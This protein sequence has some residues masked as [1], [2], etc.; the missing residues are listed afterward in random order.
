MVLIIARIYQ[1]VMKYDKINSEYYGTIGVETHLKD[2]ERNRLYVGDIVEI[3]CNGTGRKYLKPVIEHNGRMFVM[4]LYGVNQESLI[5]EWSIKRI[6][7]YKELSLGF[8]GV[9]DL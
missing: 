2:V 3:S 9:D 8:T 4:G 5:S 1:D 7:S 6:K